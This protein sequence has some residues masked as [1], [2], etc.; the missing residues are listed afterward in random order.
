MAFKQRI[1]RLE[2]DINLISTIRDILMSTNDDWLVSGTKKSKDRLHDPAQEEVE[3]PVRDSVREKTIKEGALNKNVETRKLT[4]ASFA[5]PDEDL[6]D[7]G[8]RCRDIEESAK[9][10]MIRLQKVMI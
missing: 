5:G 2:S 10:V 7:E 8:K 1:E 6:S 3:I 4:K 9:I